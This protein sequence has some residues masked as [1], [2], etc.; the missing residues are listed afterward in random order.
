LTA[1]NRNLP[2]RREERLAPLAR[3]SRGIHDA[4]DGGRRRVKPAT[5]G[6]VD[7]R[8]RP[9]SYVL[10]DK[11][12]ECADRRRAG[13]EGE[14][15]A[16]ADAENDDRGRGRVDRR[17]FR[18][19]EQR[20]TPRALAPG[21]HRFGHGGPGPLR[22]SSRAEAPERSRS[23]RSGRRTWGASRSSCTS[24]PIFRWISPTLPW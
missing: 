3:N 22:A 5:P 1:A 4:P 6:M 12:P 8:A 16:R 11:A 14:I 23:L 20:S 21:F 2:V 24:T 13:Q 7:A 18:T 10:Y 17:L 19:G 9:L 15:P